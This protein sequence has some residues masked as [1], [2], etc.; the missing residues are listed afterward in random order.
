MSKLD[1]L[2]KEKLEVHSLQP[3]AQAWEK[4][5]AHLAKK[6][7][8]VV[9]VRVAAAVAL[10]GLLTFAALNWDKNYEEPKQEL[11][12]KED[13][14]A[15][16]TEQAPEEKQPV[17]KQE[18]RRQKTE[19]RSQKPE[20]R[21]LN[22]EPGT[23]NSEQETE[24]LIEQIAVVPEPVITP[25]PEIK[26]EKGITLTYSLPAIKKP[27]AAAEPMVAEAKKTGLERVLEIAKEVKNGDNPLGELREA[28]NDILALEFRKDKSKKE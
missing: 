18:V 7:K 11:V 2:F 19:D 8:M 24:K 10:L 23:L 6:N 15:P 3:S 12:K 13:S 22:S 20:P 28:K 27:E 16:K 26:K 21:T 1:K 14:K 9:W 17:A 5:D 4:V 25:E